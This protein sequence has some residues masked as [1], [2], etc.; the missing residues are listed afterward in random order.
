[1]KPYLYFLS[2]ENE[3]HL[4]LTFRAKELTHAEKID[5]V[6]EVERQLME[7]EYSDKHLHILWD[8]GYVN[9]EFTLW[10]ETTPEKNIPQE[11]KDTLVKKSQLI[12]LELPDYLD[13]KRNTEAQFIVF[14]EESYIRS[15]LKTHYI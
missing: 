9:K 3:L 13:E 11:I 6:L 15:M 10:S 4:L 7:T 5:I 2:S 8:N 12:N 14:P 1:M